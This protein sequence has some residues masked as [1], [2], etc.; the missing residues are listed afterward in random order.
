MA[1]YPGQR[2]SA[3]SAGGRATAARTDRARG[4]VFERFFLHEPE[5]T[6]ELRGELARCDT[7]DLVKLLGS[8]SRRHD[9]TSLAAT[10][11]HGGHAAQPASGPAP[12]E[13]EHGPAWGNERPVPSRRAPCCRWRIRRSRNGTATAIGSARSC[14]AAFRD[15]A[16]SRNRLARTGAGESAPDFPEAIR[17]FE[18]SKPNFWGPIHRLRRGAAP[19][20]CRR[21]AL[22]DALQLTGRAKA[23]RRREEAFAMDDRQQA[24]LLADLCSSRTTGEPWCSSGS[25]CGSQRLCSSSCSS[26]GCGDR[27][28]CGPS[29]IARPKLW[30]RGAANCPPQAG[31]Y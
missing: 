7:A 8:P 30:L 9:R 28:P 10:D 17:S 16:R 24:K 12:A 18:E 29:S 23:A 26:S 14:R 27:E 11:V 13:P 31:R 25:A 20:A 22:G 19:P 4:R 6:A 1:G 5:L 21:K 3:R 2:L 15:I